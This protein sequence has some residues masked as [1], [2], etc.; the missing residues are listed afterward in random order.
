MKA[1]KSTSRWQGCQVDRASEGLVL[2]LGNC[3]LHC[4]NKLH[5]PFNDAKPA[6]PPSMAVKDRVLIRGDTASR[7]PLTIPPGQ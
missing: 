4:F 6:F 1:L 2:V 5:P 7:D 3:M